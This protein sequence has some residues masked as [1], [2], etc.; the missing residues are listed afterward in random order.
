VCP[1]PTGSSRHAPTPAAAASA[2]CSVTQR[3]DGRY[4]SGREQRSP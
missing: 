3:C 1:V 4:R 2:G